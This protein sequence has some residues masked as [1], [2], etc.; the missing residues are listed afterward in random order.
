MPESQSRNTVR[1]MISMLP[2]DLAELDALAARLA[3]PGLSPNRSAAFR[4]ALREYL[5]LEADRERRS[6]GARRRT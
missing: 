5:N 6:G 4:T 2:T 1:V 3:E